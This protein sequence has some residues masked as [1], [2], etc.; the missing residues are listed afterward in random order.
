M[1]KTLKK[2]TKR[3]KKSLNTI[4]NK[5]YKKTK[6][7]KKKKRTQIN[8][9]NKKTQINRRKKRKF[10]KKL[11]GGSGKRLAGGDPE[12][13]K[14]A[15]MKRRQRRAEGQKQ[16]GAT[17]PPFDRLIRLSGIKKSQIMRLSEEDLLILMVQH[18]VPNKDKNI[19][20]KQIN[21]YKKE[22][23]PKEEETANPAYNPGVHPYYVPP[24]DIGVPEEG[25]ENLK[26][27]LLQREEEETEP[28]TTHVV[29]EPYKFNEEHMGLL[30]N[31][32]NREFAGHIFQWNTVARFPEGEEITFEMIYNYLIDKDMFVLHR[33]PART[34]YIKSLIRFESRREAETNAL[35]LQ[36]FYRGYRTRKNL[37][38]EVEREA[39]EA[40]AA[41][42]IKGEEDP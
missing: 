33:K 27:L 5:S 9:K 20:R 28:S 16:G 34:E 13:P 31:Y 4:R 35:N 41:E 25:Y 3:I 15:E 11:I 2:K 7:N 24:R 23:T 40:R 26:Q 10:S 32:F 30:Y 22:S 6:I 36:R 1:N 19:I 14:V 29:G 18:N 37:R 8:K 42:E 39:G 17:E 21:H 38:Q 12:G